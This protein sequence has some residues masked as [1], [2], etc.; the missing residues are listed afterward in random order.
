MKSFGQS[1][2]FCIH[3][4]IHS[5][6]FIMPFHCILLML[7][8]CLCR[9]GQT[10]IQYL[11]KFILRICSL[12][13]VLCCA[14]R[15]FICIII[16]PSSKIAPHLYIHG[17]YYCTCITYKSDLINNDMQSMLCDECIVVYNYYI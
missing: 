6:Y 13:L 3:S 11:R 14:Q 2:V 10:S 16:M 7:V 17:Y 4:L 15:P 8:I 1:L 5:S 9:T 12:V